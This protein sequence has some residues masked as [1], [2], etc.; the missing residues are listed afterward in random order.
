MKRNSL[1]A[2][3]VFLPVLAWGAFAV[4]GVDTPADVNGVDSP[5]DV[6]G[7]DAPSGGCTKGTTIFSEDFESIADG[8]EWANDGDWTEGGSTTDIFVGDNAVSN[9]GSLSGLINQ[10]TNG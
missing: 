5:A 10:F 4:N 8:E 3:I 2:L 9:G 7:V 6:N 1:I